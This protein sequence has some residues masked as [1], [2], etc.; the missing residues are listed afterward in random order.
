MPRDLMLSMK[1][2]ATHD[3]D[4]ALGC[5]EEARNEARKAGK[6]IGQFLLQEFEMRL[7]RGLTEKLPSLLQTLRTNHLQEPGVEAGLAQL[8]HRYG[9]IDEDQIMRGRD[10]GMAPAMPSAASPAAAPTPA[11]ASSDEP[12]KLWLP[13]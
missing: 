13:E 8:L 1:A 5:L 9:L 11:S 4:E 10:H 12:S 2:E 7:G 3:N 6:P